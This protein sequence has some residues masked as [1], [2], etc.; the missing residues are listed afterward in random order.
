MALIQC[1]H[2][3]SHFLSLLKNINEL[4]KKKKRKKALLDWLLWHPFLRRTSSIEVSKIKWIFCKRPCNNK[5][6]EIKISSIDLGYN[7]WSVSTP[8][9][10]LHLATIK[11]KDKTIPNAWKNIYIYSFII[12]NFTTCYLKL[13]IFSNRS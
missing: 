1:H 8:Y 11:Y 2:W 12:Y 5:K 13:G 6:I 9:Y 10:W 3:H 7:D 4:K